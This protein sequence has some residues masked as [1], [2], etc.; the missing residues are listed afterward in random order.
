MEPTTWIKAG[1][2]AINAGSVYWIN[3]AAKWLGEPDGEVPRDAWGEVPPS[4]R[5]ERTGV[6]VVFFIHDR[7]P[8]RFPYGSP[9]AEDLRRFV[10]AAGQTK[11]PA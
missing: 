9:E 4:Q 6:E 10:E 5:L 3:T 8:L 2:F 7:D 11:A 1:A